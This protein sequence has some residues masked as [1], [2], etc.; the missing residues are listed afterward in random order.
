[1]R[2]HHSHTT[3]MHRRNQKIDP[4]NRHDTS[5]TSTSRNPAVTP[6]TML[7]IR[8]STGTVRKDRRSDPE[9]SYADRRGPLA[10]CI[11]CHLWTRIDFSARVGSAIV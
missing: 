2:L 6:G 4:H 1:M 5:H 11:Q 9:T 3:A 7:P 8:L 10:A